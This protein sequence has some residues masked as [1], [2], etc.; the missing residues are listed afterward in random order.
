MHRHTLRQAMLLGLILISTF[1][2]ALAGSSSRRKLYLPVVRNARVV[3]TPTPTP[4]PSATPRPAQPTP[5]RTPT[6]TSQPTQPTPAPTS[7]ATLD[8][9]PS[10]SGKRFSTL[11]PGASL[12]SGAE[13]ATRIRR[14]SWEPRPSNTNENQ[15]IANAGSDYNPPPWGGV[16]D[17]ANSYIL[18]RIDGKFTGTTDEI[19]QW[20]ACKWGFDEELVRAIALRETTWNQEFVGDNGITFG[21]LQVKST[22]H[23]GTAPASYKSTAWNVDYALASTRMCYEGYLTW[24]EEFWPNYTKGDLWGCVGMWY[25][26]KW[27][28]ATANTYI[29]GVK[30]ALRERPW[31]ESDFRF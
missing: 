9:P 3:K 28:N 24:A 18:P 5:T 11:A 16:D 17:R 30:D 15:Y 2:V 22:V 7:G 27:Y 25:S 26:G 12:P 29:D 20:G 1:G 31:A 4:R 8:G 10:L 14:T 19:L 6:T 13:C 21:I 23:K